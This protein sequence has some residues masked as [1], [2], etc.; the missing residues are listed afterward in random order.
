MY[1]YRCKSHASAFNFCREACI[2]SGWRRNAA[3]SVQKRRL[4]QGQLLQSVCKS[5]GISPG[6]SADRPSAA[7]PGR[8][9]VSCIDMEHR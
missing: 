7:L 6:R 3:K 5:V 4:R 8:W 1:L 2:R 9:Y